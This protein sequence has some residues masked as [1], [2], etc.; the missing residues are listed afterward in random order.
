M[1]AMLQSSPARVLWRCRQL[2]PT[3]WRACGCHCVNR[4]CATTAT[5][6][7]PRGSMSWVSSVY[8][9]LCLVLCVA[10]LHVTNSVLS[11]HPR[12][13]HA[14][15]KPPFS[16]RLPDCLRLL[17]HPWDCGSGTGAWTVLM[18]LGSPTQSSP[19]PSN[20][21]STLLSRC[22]LCQTARSPRK[23]CV[24]YVVVKVSERAGLHCIALFTHSNTLVQVFHTPA[25]TQAWG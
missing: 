11:F 20:L 25:D 12:F 19:P 24:G 23:H 9:L 8:V 10:R 6:K 16:L 1:M 3:R 15:L 22:W 14:V 13:A 4:F 5:R 21:P 2:M 7:A 18:L 17:Q